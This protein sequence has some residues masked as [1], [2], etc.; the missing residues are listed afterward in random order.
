MKGLLS[1]LTATIL[2]AA[3]AMPLNAAPI[4]VP[5]PEQVRADVLQKVDDD[6]MIYRRHWRR[7][8]YREWREDR[9]WQRRQAWRN[10]RDY[11]TCYPRRFYDRYG[12][13]DYYLRYYRRPGI[14]IYVPIYRN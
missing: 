14:S 3:F 6:M 7:K 4:F 2:A 11:N 13:R 9:H 10:C 5:R 1:V 8:H 12:E